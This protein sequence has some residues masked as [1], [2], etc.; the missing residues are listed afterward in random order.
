MGSAVKALPAYDPPYFP[1]PGDPW[2]NADYL[3]RA[4]KAI[5]R[6]IEKTVGG[7]EA[8]WRKCVLD[9]AFWECLEYSDPDTLSQYLDE[10]YREA[11]QRN[12]TEA[13]HTAQQLVRMKALAIGMPERDW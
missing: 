1:Q 13:L 8:Q 11:L 6:A 9:R 5:V 4:R 12:G 10:I 2:Y 3:H 7:T